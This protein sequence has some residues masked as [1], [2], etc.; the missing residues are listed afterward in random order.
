MNCI[1]DYEDDLIKL[2]KTHG[3]EYSKSN[4]NNDIQVNFKI[5][6]LGLQKHNLFSRSTSPDFYIT[7]SLI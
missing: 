4:N 7:K 5:V 6:N 1:N 2:F 3:V